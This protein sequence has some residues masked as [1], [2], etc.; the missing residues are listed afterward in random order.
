MVEDYRKKGF[1]VHHYPMAEEPA[2]VQCIELLQD[3]HS[4]LQKSRKTLVQ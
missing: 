3:L 2:V 4:C 1:A